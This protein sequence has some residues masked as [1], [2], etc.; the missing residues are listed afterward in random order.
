V[1][2]LTVP[3]RGLVVTFAGVGATA[4]APASGLLVELDVLDEA[5]VAALDPD[6]DEPV[7]E[8]LG[9]RAVAAEKASY[10]AL[11]GTP[12]GSPWTLEG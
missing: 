10:A 11:G 8:I 6:S 12:L 5:L 7:V 2:R 4:G 1:T 9:E 3:E